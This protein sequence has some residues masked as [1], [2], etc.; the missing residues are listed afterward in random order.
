LIVP[1][2]KIP[3]CQSYLSIPRPVVSIREIL[4]SIPNGAVRDIWYFAKG[5]EARGVMEADLSHQSDQ[6]SKLVSALRPGDRGC[7]G[8][9][10]SRGR[11]E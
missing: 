1:I 4:R 6:I 9:G 5:Y 11:V 7:Q 3:S 2:G 8:I 10:H